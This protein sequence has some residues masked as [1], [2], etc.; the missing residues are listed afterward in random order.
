MEECLSH[1]NNIFDEEFL[2]DIMNQTPQDQSSV[3]IFT[4]GLVNNN[5]SINV[6]H[7]TQHAAEKLTSS[8]PIPTTYILSYDK[9]TTLLPPT[10]QHHDSLPLSSSK[11]NNQGSNSKKTRSASETLDHIITERNRRRELTRK[12]IELSAFIPGLKKVSL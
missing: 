10:E 2:K 6:S 7:S 5:S 4:T 11:A 1:T 8:L 3:P 12:F 9:S